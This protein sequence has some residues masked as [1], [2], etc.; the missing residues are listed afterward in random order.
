MFA[1][2]EEA[3]ALPQKMQ[4]VRIVKPGGPEVLQ[5]AEMPMPAYGKQDVLIRVAAAGVNRP[6]CLQRLGAYPP[7]PGAPEIPGLEVSGEVVAAGSETPGGL[8]G[9]SVMALVAGGG[10]GEYCAAHHTNTLPVPAGLSAT[11]AAAVPETFFTV[12]HNVFQRGHLAGGE[13][14]MV[15]GGTSGIGTTAIQLAKAFGAVVIATAGSPEKCAACLRLG[16]DHA[17]DYRQ[18]D[19]VSVVE[20]ITGG[21]GVDLILDM[22]GGSYVDRNYRAAAADGRIVQI[23]LLQGAKAEANFTRLMIKRLTHTG[24][25]LRPRPVEFKAQ[26]AAELK[27]KVWPLIE[28]GRVRPVMD[29]AFALADAAGAHAR[30]EGGEHIGKIVLT[31]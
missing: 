2:L 19:F 22:F 1:T 24:S 28:A 8:V 20:E 11:E 29:S 12:W 23:A 13:V 26:I 18:Q 9:R 21:K 10:Y 4:A 25:T 15:H 14:F 17:I 30:M 31:V 7:P 16:A 6:D 5:L 27:E 3:M